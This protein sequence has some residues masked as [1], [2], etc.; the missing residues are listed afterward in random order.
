MTASATPFA[1]APFSD[2]EVSLSSF[3]ASAFDAS[4]PRTAARLRIDA[5]PAGSGLTGTLDAANEA[6]GAIDRGALP[7]TELR[8]TYAY[9]AET[10]R[11]EDLALALEGG[12]SASGSATLVFGAAA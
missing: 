11:L 5:K 4:L 3:D 9:D 12:G 8:A 6:A 1:A 7:I 10:L 2:A